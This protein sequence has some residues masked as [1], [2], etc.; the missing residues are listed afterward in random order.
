MKKTLRPG[1]WYYLEMLVFIPIF[2]MLLALLL[3]AET[4][5]DYSWTGGF[6]VFF[7]LGAFLIIRGKTK[8]RLEIDDGKLIVPAT[9]E[10]TFW[11][12][13]FKGNLIKMPGFEYYGNEWTKPPFFDG[14]DK[15]AIPFKNIKLIWLGRVQTMK[16]FVYIGT[17]FFDIQFELA[18]FGKKRVEQFLVAHNVPAYLFSPNLRVNSAVYQTNK[19]NLAKVLEKHPVMENTFKH[20]R[21]WMLFSLCFLIF[22]FF[23]WLSLYNLETASDYYIVVFWVPLMI[24]SIYLIIYSLG[25]KKLVVDEKQIQLMSGRKKYCILWET[26]ENFYSYSGSMILWSEGHQLIIPLELFAGNILANHLLYTKYFEGKIQ[27]QRIY[28]RLFFRN[29]KVRER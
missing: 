2:A 29:K 9:P 10:N 11:P 17:S 14:K 18:S 4:L 7:G 28:P 12:I 25:E 1:F 24:L 16:E 20:K 27:T 19:Q 6:L 15:F 13:D 5:W 26:I 23:F 21:L 22:A 3:Q 8:H